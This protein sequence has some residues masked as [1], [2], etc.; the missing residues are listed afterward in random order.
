MAALPGLNLSE[1][2]PVSDV[3][4]SRTQTLAPQSEYRFEVSFNGRLT[5][6][7]TSGN[8]ELFGSELAPHETYTFIG[9]KAAIFT[10]HGCILEISGDS[11][12]E[13]AAEETPM[14][15]YVNVHFA[16]EKMRDTAAAG[17]AIGPRVLVV[18]PENAGKTTLCRLLTAYAVKMER[19][20]VVVNFDPRQGLLGVPGSFSATTFASLLDVEE[21][22]GSSPISGPTE[23]PVKMPLIY[24]FGL[25]NAEENGKL[26]RPLATRMAVPVTS[27]LEEDVA[28]KA[29]GCIVDTPGSIAQGKGGSYEN[30]QHLVS[31]F[32]SMHRRVL[33]H[34]VPYADEPS[35]QRRPGFRL[36]TIVQRDEPTI[37]REPGGSSCC[38]Q[39]P[40]VRWLC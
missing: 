26:F 8:A 4:E 24:N 14:V 39:A 2:E 38:H 12:S 17:G 6:K 3:P 23:I 37:L 18:G 21:G 31:E 19:Q 30:I 32:S 13:Y 22:W 1:P 35:S 29:S 5:V 27:R 33:F 28:A 34:P 40:K 7:L 10:W 20:P 16:L 36:G 15:S 9:T 11:E 25:E